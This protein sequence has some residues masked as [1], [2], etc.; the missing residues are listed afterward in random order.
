LEEF[1][2]RTLHDEDEIYEVKISLDGTQV[3]RKFKMLNITFTKPNDRD[4]CLSASENA[5]KISK[6]QIF[7]LKT[8]IS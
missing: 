5:L 1:V 6:L 7:I 3:G 2:S 4:Y 8:I